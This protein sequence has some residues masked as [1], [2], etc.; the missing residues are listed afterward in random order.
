MFRFY[1]PSWLRINLTSVFIPLTFLELLRQGI[2]PQQI[3]CVQNKQE[4]DLINSA[5][6]L[7]KFLGLRTRYYASLLLLLLLLLFCYM[8]WRSW[9]VGIAQSVQRLATGW[10]RGWISV[11]VKSK[12]F[13]SPGRPDRL[14]DPTSLLFSGYWG[15][16][17]GGKA[18]GAWS[19]PLTSVDLYTHSPMRLHRVVLN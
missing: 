13:S 11:S 3:F 10:T 7:P 18:A 12:I 17:P 19:W 4:A 14:W 16:F 1:G 8:F 6:T 5:F 15:C 9:G 2:N